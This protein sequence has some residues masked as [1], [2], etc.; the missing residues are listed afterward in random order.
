MPVNLGAYIYQLCNSQALS[1]P[2]SQWQYLSGL[3]S[4]R[5]CRGMGGERVHQSDRVPIQIFVMNYFGW[6]WGMC[7]ES[8]SFK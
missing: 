5:G 8:P 1:I 2:N 6:N 3:L 4:G 7:G